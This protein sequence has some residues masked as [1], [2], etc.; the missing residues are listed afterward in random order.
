VNAVRAM[1]D[2]RG[3]DRS[4]SICTRVSNHEVE[5]DIEDNAGGL[6][7]DADE[8][9]FNTIYYQSADGLGMGLTICRRIVETHGGRIRA[10]NAETGGAVFTF[11]L[12][13][14]ASSQHCP[15]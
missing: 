13:I 4:V 10:R 5:V 1:K 8:A 6:P 2:K 9:L 3:K 14:R 12:P 11:S 7:D 15:G